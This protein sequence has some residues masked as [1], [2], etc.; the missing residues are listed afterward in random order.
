MSY[1]STLS[2]CFTHVP[3]LRQRACQPVSQ[4]ADYALRAKGK[5]EKKWFHVPDS[6]VS[7]SKKLN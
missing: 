3:H 6:K 7:E 1:F 4:P 2:V 5:S